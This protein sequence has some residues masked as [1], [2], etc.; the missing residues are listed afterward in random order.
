[1][2]AQDG[3]ENFPAAL[4][5]HRERAGLVRL[6]QAAEAD[7]VGQQHGG[8]AALHGILSATRDHNAIA[9]DNP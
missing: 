9:L 8:Q 2:L 7:H 5:Q 6:H 1:M 3:L 4:L